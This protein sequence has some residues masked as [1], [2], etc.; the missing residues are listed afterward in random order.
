MVAKGVA[1]PLRGC[2]TSGDTHM[3]RRTFHCMFYFSCFVFTFICTHRAPCMARLVDPP[4]H[5]PSNTTHYSY[6]APMEPPARPCAPPNPDPLSRDTQLWN[7]VFF[8]KIHRL[9][10]SF[11]LDLHDRVFR[12][13]ARSC[14]IATIAPF[15]RWWSVI[16][17]M[18]ALSDAHTGVF[19]PPRPTTVLLLVC[20]VIL[21]L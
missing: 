8:P 13:V 12:H 5:A 20:L 4:D 6:I 15:H 7:L 10:P 11:N 2:A 21:S 1:Q 16:S 9:N 18:D 14:A 3:L 19:S 17:S